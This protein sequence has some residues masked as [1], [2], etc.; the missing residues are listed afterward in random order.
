[1]PEKVPYYEGMVPFNSLLCS[2]IT[3]STRSCARDEKAERRRAYA[4]KT[5][6]QHNE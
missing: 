2:F 4:Y 1:M 5:T 6:S 3:S